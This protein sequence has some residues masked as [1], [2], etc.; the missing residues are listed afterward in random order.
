MKFLTLTI[1]IVCVN[2][3]LLFSQAPASSSGPIPPGFVDGSKNPGLIPDRAAYRLVLLSLST[4]A[5]PTT[6][7]TAKQEAVL[8]RM[9]LS[10]TD[11]TALKQALITF[12]AANS[13]WQREVAAGGPG[14]GSSQ[15]DS[16]G[17]AN[18]ENTRQVLAQQLTSDGNAKLAQFV[19]QAKTHMIVRP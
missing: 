3:A 11:K 7:E 9:G 19:T 13:Q 1:A 2:A 8:K 4:S 14:G 10:D 15:L 5:S 16:A 12:G 6:Q 17:W 18:V